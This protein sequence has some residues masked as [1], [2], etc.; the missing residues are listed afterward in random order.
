[1]PLLRNGQDGEIG[2]LNIGIVGAGRGGTGLLEVF[3]ANGDVKIV[4]IA[5]CD[6]KAPGLDLARKYGIYIAST[7]EELSIRNPHIIINATGNPNVSDYIRKTFPYPVEIIEGTS[8]WFL[9]ELVRRQQE[10]K[11][12]LAILYENALLIARSKSLQEV[13]DSILSSAMSLTETPAGSI[14]LIEG[15]YMVMAAHR[16]LSEEFFRQK[17]WKPRP[18]GLSRFILS[19]REP[20]EW[21]DIS[22]DALFDGTNIKNEGIRALLASPL[23]LDGGVVGILY[24]NDFKPR[25]FTERHKKLIQLFSAFAAHAIEKFRLIHELDESLAY[26][27]AVFDESQDMIVTT[28]N[29]GKIVKFSKGGERILGYREEELKGRKASELYINPEERD[30][31]LDI[32]KER[33][34]LFNYETQVLRKDGSPVD[35]SLTISRLRDRKGNIIGTVGISKDITEE[36]RL[37]TELARKNQELQ[38]LNE[39]LEEKVIERTR[40]LERINEELRRANQAKARFISNMSHELRTPLTSILGYS[41]LI[42]DRTYGDIN[43]TQEKYVRHIMQAGKHLLHLVNNILDL[44]KIEAGKVNLVSETISIPEVINEVVF[45]MKP[46]AEKKSIEL[47]VDV[48]SEVKDFVADRVKLKQILYNLLSNAVKFTPEGGRVGVKAEYI[49]KRFAW[50]SSAKRFLKITVWDTGIGIPEDQKERVFEE[51]EQLDPSRAT[52]GTGLGLPM[53]KRLVELHGGYIELES[54]PGKGT[55]FYVYLPAIT[56]EVVE[57]LKKKTLTEAKEEKPS[58]VLVVEDE[59]STAELIGIYLREGGYRVEFARNGIEAIRLARELQPFAV[60]LDIMLPGKDGWEVL[61]SLKSDPETSDIP[62]I[63]HSILE[64]R[65]L[66]F[67]MGATDYIVKPAEKSVFLKK[68]GE[69]SLLNKKR[70]LPVNIFVITE[71]ERCREKLKDLIESEGFIFHYYR[72][73]EEAAK[74]VLLIRP[75]ATILDLAMGERIAAFIKLLKDTPATKEIL[76]LGLTER[77][78]SADDRIAGLIERLLIKDVLS[79]KELLSHLNEIELLHPRRAG[80]IDELTGLFNYRYLQLRLIQECSRAKRY[81]IP[82]VIVLLDIDHFSHYVSKKGIYYGNIVLKKIAELLKK[83]LR[84]SDVVCRA[85]EDTFAIILTNT[86]PEPAM[87]IAKR[88]L[89]MIR[90]Y[91]FIHGEIQPKGRITVSAG[92]AEFKGQSPEELLLLTERALRLAREKGRDRVEMV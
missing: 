71:D 45:V 38:E 1:M 84:S 23:L 76:I 51:F 39:Q 3:L 44:A 40:E 52:E 36:K 56:E 54:M 2:M 27:Q 92:L 5:D 48:S 9:W 60:I 22:E 49:S 46:Q 82:L 83:N 13:L 63:I 70:R 53:T 55:C 35:I 24:L 20:V 72:D 26:L 59:P 67:L 89:T 19:S 86:L 85:G 75:D 62:V 42:L 47:S 87:Q 16:G 69:L 78:L 6:S 21:E 33:D 29:E 65:E 30:R 74:D 58:L 11:K 80:L 18:H 66:A 88:F 25:R 28:D 64:E 68:L 77:E 31:I 37:R 10:S 90:E 57:T 50:V 14:S 4:G 7:V 41:E 8:A 17:K 15:E 73:T 81:K 32:L 79:S 43:E 12:D 61:Q 91:P 34:A